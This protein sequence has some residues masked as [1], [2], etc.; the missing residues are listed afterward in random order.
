MAPR[1]SGKGQCEEVGQAGGQNQR[2]ELRALSLSG[3]P[4][5]DAQESFQAESF[6]LKPSRDWPDAFFFPNF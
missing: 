2:P 3:F 4:L 5:A 1:A 6:H